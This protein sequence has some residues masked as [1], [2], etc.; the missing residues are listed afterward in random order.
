MTS[1]KQWPAELAL[2]RGR[3]LGLRQ[4]RHDERVGLVDEVANLVVF[5]AADESSS[6]TNQSFV[7]DG[8]W[9]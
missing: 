2:A 3:A 8:G 6:I 4:L 9:I 7:I 5:L 1:W